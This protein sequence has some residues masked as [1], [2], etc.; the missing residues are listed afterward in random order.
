M[1]TK[2]GKKVLGEKFYFLLFFLCSSFLFKNSF[3]NSGWVCVDGDRLFLTFFLSK[4]NFANLL[5]FL[6]GCFF[7]RLLY[8]SRF[9][10]CFVDRISNWVFQSIWFTYSFV[11]LFFRFLKMKYIYKNEKKTRKNLRNIKQGKRKSM[12][13]WKAKN[14]K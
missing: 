2:Q 4:R 11:L 7:R 1:K 8:H 3:R 6:Y 10:F 12:E 13:V 9:I 5:I 14:E